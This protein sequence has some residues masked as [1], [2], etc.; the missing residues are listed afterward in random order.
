MTNINKTQT[1]DA[2]PETFTS[3]EQQALQFRRATEDDVTTMM[4]IRLEVKENTLSDPSKVTRQMCLDYLDQLG[5]GWVCERAGEIIG[6]SYADHGDS[7]IWALFVQPGQ[8]GLGAGKRLLQLACDYL[9][10]LG[11]AE[12]KL[13]T[14]PNTRA[15]RFYAAQGWQRGAMKNAVEVGYTLQRPGR[16][17]LPAK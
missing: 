16:L 10:G 11:H 9:F 4:R 2:L 17:T 7:S 6:F 12:V 13:G 15:D 14:T 5:R 1:G 3:Q 8:E